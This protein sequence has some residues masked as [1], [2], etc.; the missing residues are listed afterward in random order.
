MSGRD[1]GASK[2][3]KRRDD[4]D[5]DGPGPSGPAAAAT[6]GQLTS[7][8]KNKQARSEKYAKLK[9]KQKVG[10]AQGRL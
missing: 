1:G 4:E 7:F 3:R 10:G 8:I 6:V 2:K 9:S 5:D